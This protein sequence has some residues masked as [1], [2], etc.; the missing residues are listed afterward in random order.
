MDTKTAIAL[1][2]TAW[3]ED[4]VDTVA[5]HLAGVRYARGQTFR[6]IEAGHAI[7]AAE[8]AAELAR[9]S[10]LFDTLVD[11]MVSALAVR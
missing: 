10:T 4:H 9:R 2:T 3:V 8:W 7:E 11:E 5:R 1:A 6:A